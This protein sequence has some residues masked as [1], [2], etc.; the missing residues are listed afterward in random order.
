[1]RQLASRF[2]RTFKNLTQSERE[3]LENTAL[4]IDERYSRVL[5]EF[6]EADIEEMEH[7]R[8]QLRRELRIR[9]RE[10]DDFILDEMVRLQLI[11]DLE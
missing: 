4:S 5:K 9:G 11:P 1:M 6:S 2:E 10:L 7:L 8:T 3:F